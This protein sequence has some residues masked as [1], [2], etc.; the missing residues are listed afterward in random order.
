MP[1]VV[2]LNQWRK[3]GSVPDWP[4]GGRRVRLLM[5]DG[6]E[7]EG[8]LNIYD[9]FFDGESEHPLFD[10]KLGTKKTISFYDALL[11]RFADTTEPQ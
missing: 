10:V 7:V 3:E 4:D 8:T 5:R 9:Q 2:V 11:W 1:R 6:T